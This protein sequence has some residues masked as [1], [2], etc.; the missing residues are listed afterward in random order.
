MRNSKGQFYSL[1]HMTADDVPQFAIDAQFKYTG[2]Q[3]VICLQFGCGR[4]L[5]PQER[6]FSDRCISHQKPTPFPS[7]IEPYIFQ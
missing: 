3:P 6:V 4:T 2:E 5:S 7:L 1:N